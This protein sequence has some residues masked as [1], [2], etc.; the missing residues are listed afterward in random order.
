MSIAA[1]FAHETDTEEVR[2]EK[3]ATFIVAASC[4]VAGTIWTAMYWLVFGWGLIA[5]LP[6]SFVVIVG[7]ALLVSHRT[8]QHRYAVYAQILCIIYVTTFIQWTIGGVFDSGLVLVWAFCGPVTALIF[9]STRRS[10]L[11]FALYLVNVAV[12]LLFDDFFS[13][14]RQEVAEATRNIFG[15]MN[16][17][18][19]SV[20]VFLF[21]SYFVSRASLQRARAEGL[22]LNILPA[23]I[24]PILKAGKKT[25]ANHHDSVSVLFA[26]IVGSTPLFAELS[27]SRAVEWLNEIFSM[28]DGLVRKHGLE[29]IRTIGDNYMVAAGAPLP[30]ADHANITAALALDMI[31]GLEALPPR[32]GRRITFRLGINSGPVVAGVIGRAKFQYDLWGD[33]VNVASRM[34]SSGEGGRVQVSD[35]T[36][37]G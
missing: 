13:S 22:L 25:I 24:A 3:T 23:E 34:E 6:L 16:L 29:K 31:A 4:C 35:A 21:A 10:I 7:T 12:T 5:A 32:H 27:A 36:P 33:T 17:G 14:R 26:D 1:S 20:V 15:I 28:F 9:F 8:K 2:L 19:S 11:W 30:L 37:T 18:F